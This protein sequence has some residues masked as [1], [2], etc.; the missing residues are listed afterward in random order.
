MSRP[1][2]LSQTS[3]LPSGLTVI[4]TEMP[5]HRSVCVGVAVRCGSRYE[6]AA[7]NGVSH[8]LEHAL[9]RGCEDFP[10]AYAFNAAIEACSAGL[11]GSTGAESMEFSTTCLGDDVTTVIGLLGRFLTSPTFADFATERD[12]VL[13]ELQDDLDPDGRDVSIDNLSKRELFGPVGLG[14]PV[15]G[16]PR[17]VRG[18]EVEDCRAWLD[19]HFVGGNMALTVVGPVDHARVV[20][21]AGQSFSALASGAAVERPPSPIILT[22]W[23]T[24]SYLT[25]E[26]RQTELALTWSLPDPRDRE[27]EALFMAYRILDG[28]S[29]ARLPHRIIDQEGLA[30]DLG[31]GL[32]VHDQLTLLSID[33]AVSHAKCL[34]LIDR[35]FDVVGSL[36][37]EPPTADELERQQ[38][39][40]ALALARATESPEAWSS[41][42]MQDWLRPDLPPA[43][44]RVRRLQTIQ[45]DEVV[46]AAARHLRVDRV[47]AALVG[48]LPPL[49]RAG[50]RRRLHRLRPR[51]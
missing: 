13:E 44:E 37:L 43:A 40:A 7:N 9:Y 45:I 29:A 50:L 15:G 18:L 14:L 27:W 3:V 1:L 11:D 46:A 19:G 26:A 33:A 20:D 41:W 31:A 21:A 35:I 38:R 12:V 36:S 6:T 22:E 39:R 51:G 28:G 24:L 8:L 32:A 30:Y 49:A 23:P 48:D 42:L 4:T 34:P 2:T 16:C 5:Y 47:H 17:V 10:T 25:N